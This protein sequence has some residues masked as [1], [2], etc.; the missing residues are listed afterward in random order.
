MRVYLS[1]IVL[2]TVQA[3]MPGL[4]PDAAFR[5][6]LGLPEARPRPGRPSDGKYDSVYT[7]EKP[8]DSVTVDWYREQDG[9]IQ[10]GYRSAAAI[11]RAVKRA[12]GWQY[13]LDCYAD[14]IVVTRLS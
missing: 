4:K 6:L 7:L 11:A 1:A 12:G 9:S 10:K 3:K 2:K 13:H 8:G 5:R 14:R